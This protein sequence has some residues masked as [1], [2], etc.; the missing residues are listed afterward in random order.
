MLK[1]A[2]NGRTIMKNAIKKLKPFIAN[3]GNRQVNRTIAVFCDGTAYYSNGWFAIRLKNATTIPG[4][5]STTSFRPVKENTRLE[6]L[7]KIWNSMTKVAETIQFCNLEIEEGGYKYP[8]HIIKFKDTIFNLALVEFLLSYDYSFLPD[9]TFNTVQLS[10]T[11]DSTILTFS[12][13][14][15]DFVLMPVK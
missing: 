10:I 14:D 7:P 11:Q 15:M 2:N 3:F 12:K 1:S 9:I 5:Y 6:K 13:N 8:R 4:Y